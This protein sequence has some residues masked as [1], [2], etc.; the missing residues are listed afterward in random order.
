M[1]VIL[2]GHNVA[3][4]VVY[5][6]ME[7]GQPGPMAPGVLV[8]ALACKPDLKQDLAPTPHLLAGVVRVQIVPQEQILN[9]ALGELVVPQHLL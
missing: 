9:H 5:Q 7:D 2:T 4:L 8:I 3:Y 6:K 1:V